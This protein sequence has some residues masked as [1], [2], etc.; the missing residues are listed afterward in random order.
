MPTMAAHAGKG[1]V[2]I[3]FSVFGNCSATYGIC[4]DFLLFS[5]QF[6]LSDDASCWRLPGWLSRTAGLKA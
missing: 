5:S 3:K 2:F 1:A 4:I 6:R